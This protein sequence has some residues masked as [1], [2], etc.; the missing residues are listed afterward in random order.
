MSDRSL[1][2]ER[3]AVLIIKRGSDVFAFGVMDTPDALTTATAFAQAVFATQ[4]SGGCGFVKRSTLSRP[5]AREKHHVARRRSLAAAWPTDHRAMTAELASG[6]VH[7]AGD[8]RPVPD[9][10]SDAVVADDRCE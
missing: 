6:Q 8:R 5:L 4:P 10:H 1:A 3:Q 2:P 9:A 7:G